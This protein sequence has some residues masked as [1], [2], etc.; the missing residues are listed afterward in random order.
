M[1]CSF[2]VKWIITVGIILVTWHYLDEVNNW[3]LCLKGFYLDERKGSAG[4]VWRGERERDR[5]RAPT[6]LSNISVPCACQSSLCVRLGT[7]VMLTGSDSPRPDQQGLAHCTAWALLCGKEAWLMGQCQRVCPC[8][9][10]RGQTGPAEKDREREGERKK[11]T[12]RS[13]ERVFHR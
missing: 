12:A 13:C 7:P 11:E 1:S 5:D 10:Q 3:N 6:R 4:R 9:D 8:P 2:P